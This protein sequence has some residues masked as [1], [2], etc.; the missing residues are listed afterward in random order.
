M[1]FSHYGHGYPINEYL[2]ADLLLGLS[3]LPVIAAVRRGLIAAK[4]CALM[5][6]LVPA[7]YIY[8]SFRYKGPI[9]IH[10]WFDA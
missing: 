1:G 4:A 8:L 9:F 2:L 3:L 10:L 5:L 7:C 6:F